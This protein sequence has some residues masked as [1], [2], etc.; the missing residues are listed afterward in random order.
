MP[1]GESSRRYTRGVRASRVALSKALLQSGLKTQAALAA[2]MAELEDLS[3]APRDSVSRAFR[4]KPVDTKTLTRIAAALSVDPHTL[5]LTEKSAAQSIYTNS[6]EAPADEVEAKREQAAGEN[7]VPSQR[8]AQTYW[9]SS[10]GKLWIAMALVTLV[11]GGYALLM[12]ASAPQSTPN[13]STTKLA[14]V[15]PK[16]GVLTVAL[17]PS[18]ADPR[19]VIGQE[20]RANLVDERVRTSSAGAIAV[21][22][23]LS[24]REALA[25]LRTD[26]V[27]TTKRTIKGRLVT[28]EIRWHSERAND[29]LAIE[30]RLLATEE[31]AQR[32][33][34][35]TIARQLN[36]H[37][38][39][40]PAAI[41][42]DAKVSQAYLV[43]RELLADVGSKENNTAALN[44]FK[45]AVNSQPEWGPGQ[46]GLC[47]ATLHNSWTEDE[48]DALLV[49]QQACTAAMAQAPDH[50][51]SLLAQAHLLRR[52]GRAAQARDLLLAKIDQNE[53]RVQLLA[54]LAETEFALSTQNANTDHLPNA[55][56]TISTV[57]ELEPDYWRWHS[58]LATYLFYA[59]DYAGSITAAER[60]L[61]L[62]EN[63]ITFV[64]LGIAHFCNDNIPAMLASFER[65]AQ[66]SP[67]S[68][69][70]KEYLG[71]AHF[72]LGDYERSARNKAEAIRSI[73]ATGE[74]EI[75]DMWGA[76]ADSRRK[77]G[78]AAEALA[79]YTQASEIVERDFLT[80]T[81]RQADHAHRA[82]YHLMIENLS[83]R[84]L[85]E[86]LRHSILQDMKEASAAEISQSGM[87]RLAQAWH[88]LG[89]SDRARNYALQVV[90]RCAG[91]RNH[92]DLQ[93]YL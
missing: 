51:Y 62:R 50:P 33:V 55:I 92:P 5:Y 72:Y 23:S 67:Q 85:S 17:L 36:N 35:R 18:A 81:A 44:L 29:V 9:G 43:A 71:T 65:V 47:D 31:D 19:D 89:N 74:P 75:H 32:A 86:K 78:Q 93:A 76:L 14:K 54:A 45:L 1:A 16:F 2:R 77:N 38:A 52:T 24:P 22:A 63:E 11:V 91:L 80:G 82:F 8:A 28:Y 58:L 66:L 40:K 88:W 57:S 41:I 30:S 59:N 13:P 56:E 26:L 68:Y 4:E 90:D 69:L 53:T 3:S 15:E 21:D 48:T 49:A 20:L 60:A 6:P 37:R 10:S 46:A 39:A 64:N 79:A 87:V 27:L 61:R 70:A 7:R 42:P 12:P 84:P 25:M 73:G 83:E 34:G